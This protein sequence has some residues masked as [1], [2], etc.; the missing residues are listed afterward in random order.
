MTREEKI[1][2]QLDSV[3]DSGPIRFFDDSNTLIEQFDALMV[4]PHVKC[5][6]INAVFELRP[7]VPA[8]K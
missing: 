7:G 8:S 1:Q 5:D 6:L 2:Q 4:N 3:F